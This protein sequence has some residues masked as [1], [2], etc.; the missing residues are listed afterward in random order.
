VLIPVFESLISFNANTLKSGKSAKLVLVIT[1]IVEECD[2]TNAENYAI[3]SNGYDNE[4]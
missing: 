3:I 4:S 1:N 2:L